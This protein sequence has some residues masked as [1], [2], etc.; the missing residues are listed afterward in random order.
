MTTK[1]LAKDL[2]EGM[3]QRGEKSDALDRLMVLV[4]LE[5]VK[6]GFLKVKATIEAAR[7]RKGWLRRLDL[8][9]AFMGNP[10]TGKTTVAK[11][12]HEFLLESKVWPEG[13][14]SDVSSSLGDTYTG[15]AKNLARSS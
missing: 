11:L 8:N 13:C 12:Y 5:D 2:W 10:G 4:G 15:P 7:R 9:V 1:T 3:K 14:Y 6:M